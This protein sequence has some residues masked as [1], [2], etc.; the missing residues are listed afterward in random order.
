MN[1]DQ[2]IKI[3]Y[4][5][6]ADLHLDRP[7]KGL[8]K[9]DGQKLLSMRNAAYQALRRLAAI[10]ESERPDFVV[11][12][13]DIY[14]QEEHGIRSQLALRDFCV[15]LHELDIPV[16]I[17]HGNHDPLSSKIRS[18]NWPD[19]VTIF[20]DKV[21]AVPVNRD[22]E[23]IAMIH[24]ISHARS[25]EKENLATGFH[26]VDDFD[27]FQ[28]GVL[29]CSLDGSSDADRYAPCK[30]EDLIASGLD[31]W[32]LGHIHKTQIFSNQPLIAYSGVAQ[33]LQINEDGPRGCLSVS[34][35]K[36]GKTWQA[37]SE[38]RTLAPLFW[39]KMTIDMDG[40][41]KIDEVEARIADRLEE[42]ILNAPPG[43]GSYIIR[44]TLEGRTSLHHLLNKESTQRVLLDR[45]SEMENRHPA[46]FIKDFEIRTKPRIARDIASQQNLVGEIWR[47]AQS[48]QDNP[49]EFAEFSR[50]ALSP[51][52]NYAPSMKYLTPPDAE[53]QKRYLQQALFICQEYLENN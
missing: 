45:L 44:L 26:R 11:L 36:N 3:R 33:G 30:I 24:G 8:P 2:S 23:P 19:N 28:L 1:K 49:E 5:H 38:F 15:R 52:Y 20:P 22:G 42:L 29:H 21:C 17:A 13:G 10:C 16:F 41:E 35:V 37:E 51:L 7:F 18:I 31:A 9:A 27:G 32:A 47:V 34:A 4:L 39:Y 48:L 6:A 43:V 46:I 12:A 50:E 14:D 25:P 53:A 40:A